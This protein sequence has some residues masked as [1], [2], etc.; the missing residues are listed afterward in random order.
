MVSSSFVL[1]I[2]KNKL[3]AIPFSLGRVGGQERR[4]IN[5]VQC[6][7]AIDSYKTLSENV[8]VNVKIAK[9][10]LWEGDK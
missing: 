3:F 9:L 1:D 10:F 7:F 8:D 5:A 2:I 4:H 6:F